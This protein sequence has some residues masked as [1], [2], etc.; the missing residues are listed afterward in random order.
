[1]AADTPF[2]TTVTLGGSG[3]PGQGILSVDWSGREV[4][5]IDTSAYDTTG[6]K[7]FIAGDLPDNGEVSVEV[8]IDG[9]EA[10]TLGGSAASLVI[11]YAGNTSNTDTVN[12]FLRSFSRNLGDP[13][14][15]MTGTL[16]YKCT[17]AVS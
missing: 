9:S 15:V 5:S 16:V 3:V 2:G 10:P 6:A 13:D 8:L 7:T 17:G 11:T 14:S 1:M 4:A 12:A